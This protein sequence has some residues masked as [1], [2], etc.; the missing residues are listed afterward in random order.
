MHKKKNKHYPTDKSQNKKIDNSQVWQ[1]YHNSSQF[2]T[3][4]ILFQASKQVWSGDDIL[5][6][7]TIKCFLA[8]IGEKYT[9]QKK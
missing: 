8:K 9:L 3:G 4:T 6:V 1:T 7:S 2:P 5:T